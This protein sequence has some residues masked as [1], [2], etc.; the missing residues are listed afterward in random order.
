MD[1]NKPFIF[2]VA[3]SGDNFTDRE[4][5]IVDMYN[6]G[7]TIDDIMWVTHYSSRST[8]FRILD[9]YN[10][11]LNRGLMKGPRRKKGTEEAE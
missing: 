5:T 11:E 4:K 2:G 8:I 10:V 6:S 3:T 7:Y 9:K 1:N